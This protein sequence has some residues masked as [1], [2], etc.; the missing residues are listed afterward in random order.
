VPDS[1]QDTAN[2]SEAARAQK[3]PVSILIIGAN[4]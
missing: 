3:S 1:A 2:A 4:L